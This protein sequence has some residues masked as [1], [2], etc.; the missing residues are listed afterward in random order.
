MVQ[1]TGACGH[2]RSDWDNHTTC[3]SCCGCSRQNPCNISGAWP[4][5]T[6]DLAESRRSYQSRKKRSASKES[7]LHP[8]IRPL[9]EDSPSRENLSKKTKSRRGTTVPASGPP[10]GKGS[11]RGAH[12][13]ASRP[14]SKNPDPPGGLT[15]PPG[16]GSPG[17]TGSK[18]PVPPGTGHRVHSG[19][20]H[21]ELPKDRVT[22][23]SGSLTGSPG[24]GL[25]ATGTGYIPPGTG[26]PD[27]GLPDTG[28]P[29]TGSRTG[30]P[31]TG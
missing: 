14:P 29:G 8:G 22:P 2:R 3:L 7:D 13:P 16:I 31:G 30:P 1:T 12:A 20:G 19:T 24:T 11:A 27:T 28:L 5:E 17:N 25:P 18:D 4:E 21:R 6:W 10:S 15:K 23:G 26:L 9:F